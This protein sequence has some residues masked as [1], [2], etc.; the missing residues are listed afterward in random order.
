[1][2]EGRDEQKKGVQTRHTMTR[3]ERMFRATEKGSEKSGGENLSSQTSQSS[4]AY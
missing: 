2:T 3:K 4:P 1:M